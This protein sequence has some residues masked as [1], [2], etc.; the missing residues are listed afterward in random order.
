MLSWTPEPE[1]SPVLDNEDCNFGVIADVPGY[2]LPFSVT[3]FDIGYLEA[4]QKFDVVA[5]SAV[6]ILKIRWNHYFEAHVD[7]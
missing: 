5:M 1:V 6:K 3:K 7:L 2:W 4:M